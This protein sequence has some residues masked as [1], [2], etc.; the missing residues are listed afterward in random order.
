MV[1][2][3]FISIHNKHTYS[4]KE[5]ND[6]LSSDANSKVTS[7]ESSSSNNSGRESISPP[8]LCPISSIYSSSGNNVD[9]DTEC[10]RTNSSRALDSATQLTE[11]IQHQPWLNHIP[12]HY[13]LDYDFSD[14][15]DLVIAGTTAATGQN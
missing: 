6:T 8:P 4:K 9:H 7:S 15:W 1:G 14:E 13:S 12:K 5:V 3:I 2:Q 10:D 11:P